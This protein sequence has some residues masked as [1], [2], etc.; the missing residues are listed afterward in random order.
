M[1]EALRANLDSFRTIANSRARSD[2]AR[3][4]IRRLKIA[5]KVKQIFLLISGGIALIL[6][7]TELWTTRRY[8]IEIAAALIATAFLGFDYWRTQ[9]RRQELGLIAPIELDDEEGVEQEGSAA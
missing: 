8:R 1:K 4:E 7:T 6:A 3:S 9:R 2:V 5:A